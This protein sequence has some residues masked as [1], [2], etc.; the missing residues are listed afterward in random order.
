MR[1]NRYSESSSCHALV[2]KRENDYH[3]DEEAQNLND[4]DFYLDQG[5]RLNG[6]HASRTESRQ[7]ICGEAVRGMTTAPVGTACRQSRGDEGIRGVEQVERFHGRCH[8]EHSSLTTACV[9][10]QIRE[11]PCR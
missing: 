3:L 11:A 4:T 7:R 8:G 9:F 10:P 5:A 2:E 6:V 1:T